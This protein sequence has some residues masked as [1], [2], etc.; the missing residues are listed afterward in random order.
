MPQANFP[1]FVSSGI[2]PQPQSHSPETKTTAKVKP[3]DNM[4]WN[5]LERASRVYERERNPDIKVNSAQLAT[6]SLAGLGTL[7]GPETAQDYFLPAF[8][9][10][11]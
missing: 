9:A 3:P 6:I 7:A 4:R 5:F 10:A 11:Q 2:P 1:G 8:F